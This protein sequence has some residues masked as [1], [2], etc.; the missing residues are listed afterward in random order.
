MDTRC[1]GVK[2]LLEGIE[3]TEV[4]DDGLA[5]GTIVQG[6][7]DSTLGAGFGQVLPEQGMVNVTYNTT[8]KKGSAT[9]DQHEIE[10][11]KA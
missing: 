9:C 6:T 8:M 5:E 2:L 7:T 1:G 10:P 3:G 11:D 4:L